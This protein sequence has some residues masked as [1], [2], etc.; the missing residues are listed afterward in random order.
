MPKKVIISVIDND[1][2]AREGAMDLVKSLGFG[3]V[4]FQRAEDF[5]KSSHVHSTSCVVAD[6]Q[7]P[8]MDGFELLGKIRER[9]SSAPR[10]IVVTAHGSERHAVEAIKR[11]A[12][13]YFRKPFDIDELKAVVLRHTEAEERLIERAADGLPIGGILPL[14]EVLS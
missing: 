1:K 10:V 13:D 2:T 14:A 11:G 8:G 12:Y 3:V 6:V 7:M 9:G 4:A 5:L